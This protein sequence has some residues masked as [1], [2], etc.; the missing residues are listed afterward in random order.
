VLRTDPG[1]KQCPEIRH[2]IRFLPRHQGVSTDGLAREPAR[3]QSKRSMVLGCSFP[4]LPARK[5]VDSRRRPS[6]Q[7]I[8]PAITAGHIAFMSQPFPFTG[9]VLAFVTEL[10]GNLLRIGPKETA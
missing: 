6:R 5:G 4:G 3:L 7:I 9:F 2:E 1:C 8:V 10:G